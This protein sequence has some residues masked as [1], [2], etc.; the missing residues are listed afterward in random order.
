MSKGSR[1]AKEE[2]FGASSVL[3]TKRKDEIKE[4]P[5]DTNGEVTRKRGRPKGA[6]NKWNDNEPPSKES[7]LTMRERAENA[8]NQF[9]DEYS[10]VC[11][12]CFFRFEDPVKAG[13]QITRCENCGILCHKPCL[14]KSGCS[15][16]SA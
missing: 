6:K 13:K 5:L 16:C 4:L 7:K 9:L 12:I 8:A 15:E 14:D 1:K 2:R 10:E 11:N 3:K